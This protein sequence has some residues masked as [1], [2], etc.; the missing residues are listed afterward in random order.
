[1]YG[2]A[3]PVVVAVDGDVLDTPGGVAGIADALA[4]Q[5]RRRPMVIVV[6][7]PALA[8][9]V[10]RE[11]RSFM[12]EALFPEP[13]AVPDDMHQ[14][15]AHALAA[16][17]R[18]RGIDIPVRDVPEGAA[19][20]TSPSMIIGAD[21]RGAARVAKWCVAGLVLAWTNDPRLVPKRVEDIPFMPAAPGAI[22]PT[23]E[24]SP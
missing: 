23:P 22:A 4:Q 17:L 10:D 21:W 8:L 6:Q 1:M 20:H 2:F 11:Q 19:P 18:M 16:H 7:A 3:Q 13:S 12:L 15:V 24:P 14:A 9:E 5:L